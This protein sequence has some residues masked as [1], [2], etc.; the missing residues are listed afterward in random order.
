[1][2]HPMEGKRV[3]EVTFRVRENGEWKNV[4]SKELF[5]GKKVVLFALP[6]AFTPT[7]SSAHLPRYEELAPTFFDNG[8]DDILCLSVNDAFVMN[9]WGRQQ[10]AKHVKLIP[11]G[12]AEF[13][14]GMGM[15]VDKEDLGFGKRSW[16]YAM[17]VNDGI[18]EKVFSEPDKP[19]DPFEVSDADTVLRYLAP[20]ATQRPGASLIV[21]EGCQHCARAKRLLEEA[22][23]PYEEAVIGRDV[24]TRSLYAMSG[25]RTTPQVWVDGTHIGNADDLEKWLGQRAA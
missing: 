13:T 1:M 6:G 24:T 10:G 3:P 20:D 4:T 23:I 16:R 5:D 7:C 9:E 25:Q 21:K 12:N 18:I 11:D 8:V 17:V 2:T 22:G 15:L 14:A 19:G